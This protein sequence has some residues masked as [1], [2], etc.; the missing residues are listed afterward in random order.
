[1]PARRLGQGRALLVRLA[2]AAALAWLALAGPAYALDP[3]PAVLD[4]ETPAPDTP[5]E[6]L[7]AGS[8]ASLSASGT[9][10]AAAGCGFVTRPGHD[11]AQSL[12]ICG[13]GTLTIRFDAPQTSV[14]MWAAVAPF[15]EG[16]DTLT[17]E[18]WTG[19]DPGTGTLVERRQ[20]ENGS[21][22]FGVPV[23]F[24]T[25]LAAPAIR[26]VT[27]FSSTSYLIDDIAFSPFASPDTAIASG[28]AN[29]TRATDA[30][31]AFSANQSD[32]GFAC[33]LDNAPATS[34]RG[35][36]SYAG[37]ALG[38]HTFSVAARDRYGTPDPTPATYAWTVEPPAFSSPP[39]DADHD[40]VPDG[41]DDC[42][43]IANASQ[44]DADRDGV[45]DACE[46]A[47]PGTLPPV[48]GSRVVVT[49]LSGDVFIKLPA[50]RGLAQVAPIAGFVPLK[51][52]AALPTGTVVD[53][54]KGRVALD[55]TV[56]GRRIGSGGKTQ[57]A[58]LAAG[59]FR[60]RQLQAEGGSR[61]P[62]STDFVLT[63]APGAE[64]ACVRTGSSGPIK[65]RGRSVVRALTASTRKGVFRIVGAAGAS[66][67]HSATW[68]TEDRCT[69][70]RTDVG[71]GHVTVASKSSKR[72]VTV[73]AG[74]SYTIRA[75]L[76]TARRSEK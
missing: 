66:T 17:A 69:G 53:A 58:T 12:G 29:P 3:A 34:C 9:S 35:S 39:A 36:V 41:S 75:A 22:A 76:F 55:S 10:S 25:D 5:V 33:S 51:G 73:R 60:I 70:T 27:V 19:S 54:R 47:A 32:T 37:L 14:S 65:G 8:G 62:V 50:T 40:T 45:G 18:A 24:G 26:S 56:D 72:T 74:R 16:G 1:V 71:R 7:Y 52:V 31:F 38:P 13:D 46:V 11:S 68:V 63:S 42:P 6:G 4:F 20:I 67:A 30:A 59:I 61:T 2:A 44:G 43:S 21:A 28:P 49:V 23:V 64:A 48:T 57:R 15:S